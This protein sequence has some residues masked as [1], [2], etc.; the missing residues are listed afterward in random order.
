MCVE[1]DS[2]QVSE[3]SKYDVKK[4]LRDANGNGVIVGLT[5][6]SQVDGTI[7]VDGVK[8]ECEGI[9]RYRGY[10]IEDLTNGFLRKRYGFEEVAFLV[11]FGKLPTEKEL[12]EFKEILNKNRKLPRTF[13]R[14]VIMKA[15]SKD[16]MN[17]ISR[18]V[19][20][21]ASYDEDA[22]NNDLE[23]VLRQC[24]Y[25]ITVFPMLTVYSYHAYNHYLNGQSMYIHH[26]DPKLSAAENFLRMLRPDKK[27]TQLEATVL[28]L[29]LVLHMEHGGG[30][31][32]TFTTRVT[33]S[34]GSDTYAVIAAA[35]SSLKGPKHG[36]ANL[37][38]MDM[39]S[40]IRKHVKDPD[41]KDALKAYLNKILDKEAF[42]K[43]GLIYGMGH[44]IYTKSD[45]RA[46]VFKSFVQDL[47][48]EKGRLRDFKYYHNIEEIA[49]GLI[50]EHK[51][52]NKSVCANVD[53][54]S[55]FVY[56]MLDIP[57]E[58]Y[59]PLFATAR[60]IGWSAH[61]IE[62]LISSNKILR[63]AYVNIH[64]PRDYIPLEKR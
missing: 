52:N 17:A 49:P 36:G 30:N 21:L 27:Y 55:G 11:L 44:A 25:L 7:M 14:D 6:V 8:T 1:N 10:S 34:S 35:M 37:K 24:L 48:K 22:L 64:E 61:R 58:V 18:E 54:Y 32:S 46:N 50:M 47:A 5:E 56:D 31:N 40:D 28:D 62:E 43:S 26:P 38:V 45:P 3:Y 19:L 15:A 2:F 29:A 60:I 42:D 39:M 13:T 12:S 63:P 9:L 57:K 16:V 4:G 59:T 33:T 20:F 23:N 53:F 51:H 41:D